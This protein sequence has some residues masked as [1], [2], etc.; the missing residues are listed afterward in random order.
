MQSLRSKCAEL[1]HAVDKKRASSNRIA[2]E[3]QQR[4]DLFGPNRD[5]SIEV[6]N[7]FSS[8]QDEQASLQR[9]NRMMSENLNVGIAALQSLKDQGSTLS[10]A[11]QTLV[12]LTSRLGMSNSLLGV[13]ERREWGNRMLVFGGMALIVVVLFLVWYYIR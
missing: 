11:Q 12:D 2:L 1:T 9:S 6:L 4:A 5:E 8:Y 13:I 3:A 10:R 7:M